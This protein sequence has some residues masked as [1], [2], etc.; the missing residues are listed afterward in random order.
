LNEGDPFGLSERSELALP[1]RPLE[2]WRCASP[3]RAATHLWS[4][5][6]IW[7]GRA[8]SRPPRGMHMLAKLV[9][10]MPAISPG[11]A[12]K[13]STNRLAATPDLV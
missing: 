9:T 1:F 11:A 2:S 5:V 12:I 3:H 13:C 10:A 4:A 6:W 7:R 8:R